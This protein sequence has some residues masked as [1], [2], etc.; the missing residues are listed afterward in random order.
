MAM[1]HNEV[2][3][4]FLY[5]QLPFLFSSLWTGT[6][7][8]LGLTENTTQGKAPSSPVQLEPLVEPREG[9]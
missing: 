3:C 4:H 5:F 9:Y 2:L 6:S 7:S 8:I 1:I